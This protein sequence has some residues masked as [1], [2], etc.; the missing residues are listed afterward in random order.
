MAPQVAIWL[1]CVVSVDEHEIRA[2]YPN[3]LTLLPVLGL[4]LLL[5]R[6]P[7]PYQPQSTDTSLGFYVIRS[8]QIYPGNAHSL[9]AG[10]RLQFTYQSGDSHHLVLLAIDNSG[11]IQRCYPVSG[12]IPVEVI[13]GEIHVLDGSFPL[14][15][16]PG[17]LTFLGFFSV[18]SVKEAENL[19][20]Q[21]LS[22][23]QN[24][25]DS[26]PDVAILMVER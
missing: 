18:D 4:L 20:Y 14:P 12:E 19:A 2:L 11:K 22:E 8:G 17:P 9:Q 13:P 6:A 3:G 5:F 26:R 16:S 1:S 21:H 24:F 15:D 25:A 23:I 10:D 7:S